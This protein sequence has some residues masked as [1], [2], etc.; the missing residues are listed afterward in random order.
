MVNYTQISSK[1]LRSTLYIAIDKNNDIFFRFRSRFIVNQ[2]FVF[3]FPL[4]FPGYCGLAF[5]QHTLAWPTDLNLASIVT[6]FYVPRHKNMFA[7]ERM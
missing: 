2:N 1:Y 4:P 3:T 7:K 5:S 6:N